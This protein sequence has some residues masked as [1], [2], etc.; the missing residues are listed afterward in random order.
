MADP[1]RVSRRLLRVFTH[2]ACGGCTAAVR[3]AWE[4]TEANH[5][6][7]LRTVSLATKEGLA[8]AHAEKVTTIPTIILSTAGRELTR[9][10]GT[11]TNGELETGLTA[12]ASA[13]ES[14]RAGR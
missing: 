6:V 2:P 13:G 7:E 3:Q 8:E 9:W 4:L 11:P 1:L 14:A 12:A 10:E 5:D